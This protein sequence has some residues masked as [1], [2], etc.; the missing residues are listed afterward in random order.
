LFCPVLRLRDL[1]SNAR[2]ILSGP[3]RVRFLHGMVTNDIQSL[4]PGQGCHAAMLTTKGKMQADLIVYCDADRLL[5]EVG[6]PLREKVKAALNAHMVVDDVE[7]ADVTDDTEE[8]GVYGDEAFPG[9]ELAPYHFQLIDG[10]RVARTPELGGRGFHVFGPAPKGEAFG[11]V[12]GEDEAEILRVEAGRPLYGK[13]MGEDRL[14]IEAGLDDAVS[15]TKGCYLGQEV[16][17]RATNLGHIN[18]K[19]VGLRLPA[20]VEPGAKL[21]APSRPD[22]G[23]VTSTVISQKYGPIALAY[24]HRTLWDEGTALT[25]PDGQEARVV[26][27]PFKI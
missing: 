6:A 13:D 24:V 17:A 10:V 18:K 9:V 21:S 15:F 2:L 26:S 22:A 27:L 7:L 20:L 8:W 4:K 11:E 14:P 12:L 5:V 16:I 3:D 1:R 19:L 25:L 23:V